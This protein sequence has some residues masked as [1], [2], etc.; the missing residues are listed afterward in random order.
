MN[1]V[2]AVAGIGAA[3]L[4]A[5]CAAPAAHVT[6]TSSDGSHGTVTGQFLREGGPIGRGGQQPAVVRLQGLVTFTAANHR[7][8]SVRVGRSG[9]FAVR[10]PVGRYNVSGRSP[11]IMEV[12]S[13][14]KDHETPCS[15]PTTVTVIADHVAKIRVVCVVP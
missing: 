10:L 7:Q 1:R 8:V 2:Q 13:D 3:L 14:G 6:T 12:T 15:V 9:D 4:L 11:G 5:G